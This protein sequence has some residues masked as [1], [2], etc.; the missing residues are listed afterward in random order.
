MGNLTRDPEIRYTPKGTPVCEI[1]LA[2][3]RNW[4][5]DQ[6][7]KKTETTFVEVTLWAR[8]AEV[9]GQYVKKGNPLFVEGRLQLETW[10]DKQT[11]QTRSKLK[12]I[13]E[14]IQLLTG[15]PA[16]SGAPVPPPPSA[17]RA[18]QAPATPPI[19][20]ETDAPD[21]IPF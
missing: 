3:N 16:Q 12:V 15:R 6:G 19:R 1:S 4:T 5:D 21:D 14:N 13:G 20:S 8:V 10:Q 7:Q 2:I 11:N 9:V 18:S 17:H